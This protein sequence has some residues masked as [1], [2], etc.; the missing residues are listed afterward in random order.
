MELQRGGGGRRRSWSSA[1]P[2]SYDDVFILQSWPLLNT[3]AFLVS[4]FF[5]SFFSFLFFFLHRCS[6]LGCWEIRMENLI[7]LVS[8]FF[9]Y[10][11]EHTLWRYWRT[12]YSNLRGGRSSRVLQVHSY[13]IPCSTTLEFYFFFLSIFKFSPF[14]SFYDC[15]LGI[16][17]SAKVESFLKLA[18]TLGVKFSFFFSSHCCD[19]YLR[20]KIT[21][22]LEKDWKLGMGDCGISGLQ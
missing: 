13:Q 5:L 6:L 22:V 11:W 18:T 2:S 15:F 17:S 3:A 4:L 10:S 14:M 7:F 20:R 19:W 21:S 9:L 1:S 8:W 12:A 16:N